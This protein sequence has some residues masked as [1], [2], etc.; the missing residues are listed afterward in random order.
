MEPYIKSQTAAVQDYLKAMAAKAMAVSV[1]T[2]LSER[3]FG[4]V[5][6]ENLVKCV[7]SGLP[8][9][10][11]NASLVTD[12]ILSNLGWARRVYPIRKGME[13]PFWEKSQ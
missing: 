10:G 6:Y 13:I 11:V 9:Q 1:P 8:S 12:V 2:N 4:M 7:K 3:M 5:D